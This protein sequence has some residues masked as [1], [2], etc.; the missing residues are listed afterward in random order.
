MFKYGLYC[1][2]TWGLVVSVCLCGPDGQYVIT[3]A[4]WSVFV[5]MYMGSSGQCSFIWGLVVSVC[6]HG[7]WMSVCVYMGPD[8]QYLFTW[9]WWSVFV[10]MGLVV[11][12]CLHWPGGQCLFT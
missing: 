6:L 3:L 12:V 5:Y 10:Y 7:A 8:G 2:F 1:L 9:A 4:W 11:S